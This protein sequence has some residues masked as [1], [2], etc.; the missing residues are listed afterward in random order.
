MERL[1]AR[2]KR[3]LSGGWVDES[4]AGTQTEGFAAAASSERTESRAA[5][6]GSVPESG[7]GSELHAKVLGILNT[8]HSPR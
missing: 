8:L 7:K 3:A 2:L 4:D 1:R 5:T 6:P